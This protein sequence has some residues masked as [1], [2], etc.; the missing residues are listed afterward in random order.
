MLIEIILIGLFIFDFGLLIY[1][2]LASFLSL[3]IEEKVDGLT[4]F[5]MIDKKIYLSGGLNILDIFNKEIN[6]MENFKIPFNYIFAFLTTLFTFNYNI[7]ISL[8][9]FRWIYWLT[10]KKSVIASKVNFL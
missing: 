4:F 2:M 7:I 1:F 8:A 9:S 3:F 5:Q 10:V 6:G